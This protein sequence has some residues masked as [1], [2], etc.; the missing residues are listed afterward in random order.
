MAGFPEPLGVKVDL[1]KKVHNLVENNKNLEHRIAALEN[2]IIKI[3]KNKTRKT[4]PKPKSKSKNETRKSPPNIKISSKQM[5]T[6]PKLNSN[7]SSS[8]FEKLK[9]G[10]YKPM[11]IN[12]ITKP[13]SNS[14]MSK[15]D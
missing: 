5:R 8:L 13:K 9:K 10:P 6:P 11:K 7:S 3:Q 15:K 12:K 1:E 14:N 4:S 2:L